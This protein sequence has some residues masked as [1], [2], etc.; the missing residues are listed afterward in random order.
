MPAANSRRLSL[1]YHAQRKSGASDSHKAES[2]V[3]SGGYR[4]ESLADNYSY[5]QSRDC[6]Y[7]AYE[8]IDII[9]GIQQI[10][11]GTLFPLGGDVIRAKICPLS[12]QALHEAFRQPSL[13]RQ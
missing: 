1:P 11:I 5:D 12:L 9:N 7:P 13:M 2:R 4:T 10:D 8:V 3:E 6:S